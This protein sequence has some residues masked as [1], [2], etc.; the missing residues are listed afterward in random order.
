MTVLV[1][2][3]TGAIGQRL[4][5][6]L[7]DRGERVRA[8]VRSPEKLPDRLRSHASLDVIQ[9]SLLDLDDSTMQR[10]VSGCSAIASCLGHPMDLKGI[11]GPPRRLV[12]DA[13]RRLC[14]AVESSATH[15]PVRFVLM[16]TAGVRD[17]AREQPFSFAERCLFGLIRALLPPQADNEQAAAW[18]QAN[19]A[20]GKGA[21]EWAIVRPDS[22][23]EEDTVTPYTIHPSPT[24]SPLFNAGKT[25]RINV[26]HFMADLATRDDLWQ[27]WRWRMP[28]LYNPG[29][30]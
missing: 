25:S 3:A 14:N 13:T 15:R 19:L 30:S 18:L 6:Q 11:Y 27:A 1:V 23:V 29:F 17:R 5:A 4:V 2:G 21:I 20:Q 9:A 26:A 12:A 8:V 16:N 7:L 22:L 24:R 10:T 28:T